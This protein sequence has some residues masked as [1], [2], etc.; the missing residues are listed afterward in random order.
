M[1]SASVIG[2]SS[3]ATGSASSLDF[4]L[5]LVSFLGFAAEASLGVL[6]VSLSFVFGVFAGC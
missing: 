2:G 5:A 4:F 3:G 1:R 6:V